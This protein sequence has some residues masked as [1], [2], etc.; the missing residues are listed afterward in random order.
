MRRDKVPFLSGCESRPAT[1]APALKDL[2]RIL[3]DKTTRR[4]FSPQLAAQIDLGFEIAELAKQDIEAGEEPLGALAELI[5]Q[6]VRRDADWKEF[7]VSRMDAIIVD[8]REEHILQSYV[9][10]LDAAT[11]YLA[12]DYEDA[13]STIQTF[14]DTSSVAADDKGWYLQEM[15]RYN[16]RGNRAESERLQKAAHKNNRKLLKLPTMATITRLTTISQKRI[17]RVA[18]WVRDRGDYAGLEASI[19]DI[20]SDLTASGSGAVRDGLP[21]ERRARPRPVDEPDER[22]GWTSYWARGYARATVC[23]NVDAAG[24]AGHDRSDGVR[25]AAANVEGCVRRG[26]GVES[27]RVAPRAPV[28]LGREAHHG[29]EPVCGGF[30]GCRARGGGPRGKLGAARRLAQ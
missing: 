10:E 1:V 17:E 25:G 18:E 14:L 15:A 27:A 13:T 6:C 12:G 30:A 20:L 29:G 28:R 5:S 22:C 21:A 23:L 16:W 7:Y 8:R 26:R 4:H 3:R 9:T 24:G 11:A 19:S 2:V